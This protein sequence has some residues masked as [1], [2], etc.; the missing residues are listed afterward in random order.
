M[1]ETRAP[2]EPPAEIPDSGRFAGAE[3]GDDSPGSAAEPT[4]RDLAARARGLSAPYLPGGRDPEYEATQRRERRYL[5]ALV[6]MVA[7]IVGA[8]IVLTIAGF[9]VG[10]IGAH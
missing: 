3:P 2:G 5:I 10:A 8:T 7:L 4:E 6:G 9:I 1:T